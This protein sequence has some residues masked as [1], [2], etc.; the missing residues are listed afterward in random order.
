MR[1]PKTADPPAVTEAPVEPIRGRFLLAPGEHGGA[2][3]YWAT[4]LCPSCLD[5]GCGTQREPLDLTPQGAMKTFLRLKGYQKN[6]VPD[7]D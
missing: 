4:G 7:R 5:H 3:L 1:G 2:V 6:G